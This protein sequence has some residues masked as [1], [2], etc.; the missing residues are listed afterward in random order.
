MKAPAF[1]W[2]DRASPGLVSSLLTPASF[3]WQA[4]AALRAAR[5]DAVKAPVPVLCI[6]N[7]T[8]GGAGKSPMVAALQFRLRAK[9]I[10]AHVVSRG[11]GGRLVGPHQ[12][13]EGRD[14]FE[15]VGD[16]PLMLSAN[17]P[18]WI[19]RQRARAA[20][21]AADA[22]A[23]LV[24]L[25]DGFQNPSLFKNASIVMVDAVQG[26]GN[27]RVIP[28]GPLREPVSSGLAR[29]DLVVV[30]GTPEE[31]SQCLAQWPELRGVSVVEAELVPQ[32]TGLP[33][34]GEAVV[35]FA[36]IGRPE[37]FFDTLRAMGAELVA[38][39]AFGDHQHY[40]D[41]ILRRLLREA[42]MSDAMLV[43]TEK[44]AV[45]L[46]VAMRTEVMTVQV[47]LEPSDWAPIDALIERLLQTT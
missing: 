21:K 1:W 33:I 20:S 28:A 39:H 46:P 41:A 42:R 23:E 44:D 2:H 18:V 31:R 10:N 7:L 38:T 16:E 26:F 35:A 15:D 45:R 36:G 8:A 32:R 4:G 17:G 47:R 12:V 24:V 27:G 11:Y 43:T 3:L 6:G 30:V 22:D 34:S 25:D 37:K 9:Q 19:A 5:S 40:S 13:V 29:A 14:T